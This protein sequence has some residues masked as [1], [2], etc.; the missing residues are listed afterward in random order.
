MLRGNWLF[1]IAAGLVLCG[2]KPPKEQPNGQAS[3]QP[4]EQAAAQPYAPYAN[5]KPD[6]CY[7][8]EN[9]DA[10]DLCAQ[11]RAAI[12]AEKAAHE[13]R[14]STS[15]S[16]IATFLS[17][18]GLGAIVVSLRQTNRALHI[19]QRDRATATRRA[20]AQA[21]E[22]GVALEA[23]KKNANAMVKVAQTLKSQSK[24][25]A[26]TTATNKEIA[27]AQQQFAVLQM[28][29]YLTVESGMAIYQE[30]ERRLHFEAR[31]QIINTGNTPA[32]NLAYSIAIDV[33]P[34]PLP[35]GHILPDAP[36][37]GRQGFIPPGQNRFMS[38]V[39]PFL[40]PEEDIFRVIRREGL[41]LYAWGKVTYTDEFGG[42]RVTN[43][44]N[45]A[46]DYA[47]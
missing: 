36:G 37:G 30:T 43:F 28:R 10:A 45:Y 12:A 26:E 31:P 29:A 6:P 16:I 27:K 15:W 4:T 2:A 17:L 1:F 40:V 39:Y 14:R 47:T 33:L 21:G 18:I 22:T 32:K 19:A 46:L 8:A 38:A 23:A 9:H 20:V 25:V 42:E 7:Q 5:Y 41:A 11:W 35:E 34:Y 44:G 3:T 24:Y 13:A